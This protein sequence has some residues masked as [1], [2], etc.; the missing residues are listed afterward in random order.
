[1][2]KRIAVQE[3]KKHPLQKRKHLRLPE[4]DYAQ[5]GVYFVT[6]CTKGKVCLFG[7]VVKKAMVLNEAG[8]MV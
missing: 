3:D 2:N 7:D 8:R 6:I 4:Y 1:M 5:E